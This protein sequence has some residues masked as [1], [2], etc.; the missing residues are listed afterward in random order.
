MGTAADT[1]PNL[2]R[3]K[4]QQYGDRRVAMREKAYGIWQA[5][6]WGQYLAQVR[7]FALGL[8]HLGFQR[9]DKLAIIGDNRPRLYWA[10][11]AAEALGGMPV[12]VYQDAIAAEI[13]YVIDHSD[14]K[15]ILAED[16]EQVDKILEMRHQLANVE[17]VI[18]DDPKGM[19]QYAYPFLLSFAEVQERGRAFG[20][21]HPGYFEAALDKGQGEDVAI[22]NYTSGTTGAPKG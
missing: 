6:S 7:D 9:D 11:V 20:Q 10:L 17:Y 12:P 21:A 14:A 16:Q 3:A 18:Y 8:A 15:L 2:L 1:L 4:A 22:I 19:R 13:R 5:Y